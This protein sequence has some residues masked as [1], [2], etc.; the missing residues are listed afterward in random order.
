MWCFQKT[1]IFWKYIG[2]KSFLL[3]GSKDTCFLDYT[4]PLA[5]V[6]VWDKDCFWWQ[7]PK[8]ALLRNL[9]LT[10]VFKET[11]QENKSKGEIHLPI[12]LIHS[13]HRITQPR[14]LK[15]NISALRYFSMWCG[16]TVGQLSSWMSNFVGQ[17]LNLNLYCCL[18]S[19]Q[20]GPAPQHSFF[21]LAALE[22]FAH[23]EVPSVCQE[24]LHFLVMF[25]MK[26]Q[27]LLVAFSGCLSIKGFS[28][29]TQ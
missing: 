21:P 7:Q 20:N 24:I 5:N 9:Q 6:Q 15:T 3:A 26:W 4:G 22:T 17:M 19:Q 2:E 10:Q 27:F 14:Q 16:H 13:K 28:G 25:Y 1:M 18:L 29:R 11:Q 8:N 12:T 23:F